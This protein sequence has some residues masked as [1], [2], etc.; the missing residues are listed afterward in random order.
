MVRAARRLGACS[1]AG[2]TIVEVLVVMVIMGILIAVA[3]P[4]FR[5]QSKAGYDASAKTLATT[6][7]TAAEAYAADHEKSEKWEEEHNQGPYTNMTA[8]K[9]REY[10]PTMTLCPSLREA[11]LQTVTVLGSGREGYEIMTYS[12][13]T[14]DEFTIIDKLGT[15]EHKCKH[16]AKEVKAGETQGGC[17]AG[18]W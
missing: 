14:K 15:V 11:C 18:T 9:L 16:E 1:D 10:Q 8:E 7:A 6:A 12:S 2:F 17:R 4:T 3:I 5:G 13:R